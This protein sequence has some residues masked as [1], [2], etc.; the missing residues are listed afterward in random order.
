MP[1][2][3]AFPPP[4]PLT[5]ASWDHIPNKLPELRPLSQTAA[6]CPDLR[7]LSRPAGQLCRWAGQL[8][9]PL[10]E[11][12]LFLGK[13]NSWKNTQPKLIEVYLH[14]TGTL[15]LNP[16]HRALEFTKQ[17]P[18]G[19]AVSLLQTEEAERL[20]GKFPVQK[21]ALPTGSQCLC[22]LPYSVLPPKRV[23][24]ASPKPRRALHYHLNGLPP[25]PHKLKPLTCPGS[26]ATAPPPGYCREMYL[27]TPYRVP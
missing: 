11:P 10:M 27:L 4:C 5:P 7:A 8:F 13:V 14:S 16:L 20:E 12:A 19:W 24:R 9:L 18:G 26:T 1:P 17:S 15:T 25:P 6:G 2:D 21:D 23:S 22:L 3:T